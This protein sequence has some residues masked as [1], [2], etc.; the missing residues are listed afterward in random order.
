M[1]NDPTSIYPGDFFNSLTQEEQLILLELAYQGMRDELADGFMEE[2][3]I[4]DI[5]P[6][7]LG[8]LADKL[9]A[10]MNPPDNEQ[11]EGPPGLEQDNPGLS[12]TEQYPYE[13]D[14]YNDEP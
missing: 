13:F 9:D 8:E 6:E 12:L 5:K 7:Y 14:T 4:L 2:N 1:S 11:F 10:F 3:S